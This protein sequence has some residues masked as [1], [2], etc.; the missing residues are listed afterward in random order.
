[1]V[2]FCLEFG[3]AKLMTDSTAP[4][5]RGWLCPVS[6][7]DWAV[8][9]LAGGSL[10]GFAVDPSSSGCQPNACVSEQISLH[11]LVFDV[12]HSVLF[13]IHFILDF[14]KK[15]HISLLLSNYFA[16]KAMFSS[17]CLLCSKPLAPVNT[18]G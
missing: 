6:N 10:P 3:M 9:S 11:L 14:P 16:I 18:N 7:R 4:T 2:T 15:Q 12:V 1:M 8:S 5:H 13:S 17:V